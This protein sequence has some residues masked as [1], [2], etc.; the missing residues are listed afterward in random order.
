MVQ[1]AIFWPM[2]GLALVTVVVTVWLVVVRL[3]VTGSGEVDISY[4]TTYQEGTEP[5]YVIQA[6]RNLTNLFDFPLLFYVVCTLSYLASVVDDTQM[7][8]AWGFVALRAIH[9]LIH[10]SYN[11]VLHR[12]GVFLIS[13]AVLI[14]LW[15]RLATAL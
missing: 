1:T 15:V 11:I 10:L 3:K 2:I 7:Y 4:Y 14:A 12:L 6:S 13:V 8:L 9:S 5:D